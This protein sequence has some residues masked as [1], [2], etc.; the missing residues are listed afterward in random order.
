MATVDSSIAM[1]F[2]PIQIQD[3]LNRMA[4]MMQ[5]ESGQNQNALAQYQL[6]SAKRADEK[7]NFLNQRIAERTNKDTGA[8]DYPNLYKDVAQGGFGSYLPELIKQQQ[9]GEKEAELIKK[10][11]IE[12]E[13]LTFKQK[14]DKQ[15]KALAA[16]AALD[17][18]AAALADINKHLADG[19]IDQNQAD[20]LRAAI[21]NEPNFRNWQKST[22]LNVLDAKDRLVTEET[23]RANA[24]REK[25]A[26]EQLGVS[27]GQL[28]VAQGNLN[29][30]QQRLANETNPEMIRLKSESTELG[31]LAAGQSPLAP[32]VIAADA[33]K[34]LVGDVA[35]QMGNSYLKLFESGGIKS[36]SRGASAN[37]AASSQSSMLGQ[38]GG[39]VLG[40]ENQSERDFIKS[41]R[42]ILVQGIVKATG[43]TASQINSNVELKNLLDAATDP[44]KGYET[45]AKNL[46]LIN[47]RFGTGTNIM[48]EKPNAITQSGVNTVTTSDGKTYTFPTPAA[49]AQFKQA[50]G[51]K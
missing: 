48:P 21:A 26:A 2:K 19:E 11:K 40:T 44:D 46:N 15:N 4:S 18:P 25:N 24:A 1:G 7:V 13:G 37:L 41:Q 31:K 12:T 34:N 49:A 28:G 42:P 50:A 32:K 22:L 20:K 47:R 30:S 10:T 33:G 23:A 36:T 45:N 5:I 3:P 16:I 51:I 35:T 17:T 39:G 27:K 8:I 9:A 38:I 43:M 6:A 29:V 14:V